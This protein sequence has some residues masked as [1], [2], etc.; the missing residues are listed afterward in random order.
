ME[1]TKKFKQVYHERNKENQYKGTKKRSKN[2]YNF[3]Q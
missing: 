3:F 1:M 2:F